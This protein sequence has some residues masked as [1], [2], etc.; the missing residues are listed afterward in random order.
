MPPSQRLTPVFAALLL[1]GCSVVGTGHRTVVR[2]QCTATDAGDSPCDFIVKRYP[3][4]VATAPADPVLVIDGNGSPLDI[5]AQE[6][7]RVADAFHA[8]LERKY[9][10]P[11]FQGARLDANV[12]DRNQL[13]P[14]LAYDTSAV[15]PTL[16]AT[17]LP[18]KKF[19][20]DELVT[21]RNI[22]E[23]Q[24][25]NVPEQPQVT[26]RHDGVK[27]TARYFYYPRLALD[28]SVQFPSTSSYDRISYLALIVSLQQ[29]CTDDTPP[30]CVKFKNFAP[31][32][33]ELVDI[34]RGTFSQNV[35]AQLQASATLTNSLTNAVGT[36]PAPLITKAAGTSLGPSATGTFAEGYTDTLPD[37]VERRANGYLDDHTFFSELRSVRQVRLAG[38]YS[39][40][41]EIEVPSKLDVLGRS[42]PVPQELT[43]DI[44][45]MGVVRHVYKRGQK[46]LLVRVP[47]TENDDV[48]EQVILKTYPK[49]LVWRRS[50][51][52]FYREKRTCALR[53]V[54]NRD[55]A[56]FVVRDTVEKRQ[57]DGAGKSLVARLS[58]ESDDHRCHAQVEFLPIPLIAD[59][60]KPA[61]V[62]SAGPPQ[63]V[64]V[65]ASA[66][67]AVLGNYEP[68]P[69][70]P[71]P[72]PAKARKGKGKP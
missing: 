35:T 30:A 61:V 19:T 72:A 49:T 34:S 66:Y 12:Y 47:E 36:S 42:V 70:P 2:A 46:G 55:D 27:E 26:V 53:V 11:D 67:A 33:A 43:A 9:G 17:V 68:P 15:Y 24:T 58:A 37:E 71:S 40:D 10:S 7:K 22:I 62:L 60:T 39:Y 41:F 6:R 16:L 8:Y 51:P 48:Y 4:L 44:Y 20:V 25:R 1:A 18:T 64:S 59:P 29:R 57:T 38:T 13:P 56:A 50:D 14:F 21:M 52:D 23:A 5:P 45:L 54:T 28:F 32:A 65:D 63:E 31:K 69:P 3:N